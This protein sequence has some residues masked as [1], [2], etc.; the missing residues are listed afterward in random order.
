[1][2]RAFRA[3]AATILLLAAS[4]AFANFH[5]FRIEQ[6]YSNADG[7]VQFIVMHEATGSDGEHL[8][9]GQAAHGHRRPGAAIRHLPVE[10]SERGHGRTPCTDRHA[11]LCRARPRDPGFHDAD[12]VS[13]GGRRHVE[14][15]RRRSDHVFVPAHGWRERDQSQRDDDAESR[16]QFRGD[17][18]LGRCVGACRVHA[19]RSASG[20]IRTNRAPA[21]TSTSSTGRS[22]SRYSPTR[23]PPDIRSGT[24][25]RAR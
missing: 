20:G 23:P 2:I 13:S 6:L 9:S 7:T 12:R 19:R 16:H 22:S 17:L 5:L 15:C 14:L 8:W 3:C 18:G 21:T 10:S 25:P 11:G 24:S 4:A 1:M